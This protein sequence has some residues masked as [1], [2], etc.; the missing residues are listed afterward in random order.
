MSLSY[1]VA[2][3][4]RNLKNC[5]FFCFF[6]KDET[7]AES[8]AFSSSNQSSVIRNAGLNW[9]LCFKISPIFCHSWKRFLFFLSWFISVFFCQR[10]MRMRSCSDWGWWKE[11]V[12]CTSLSL[13]CVI[14]NGCRVVEAFSFHPPFYFQ[15]TSLFS[16]LSHLAPLHV[17]QWRFLLKCLSGWQMRSLNFFFLFGS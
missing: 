17:S 9:C 12:P 8:A 5:F 2:Q 13:L 16:S 3:E 10:Q 14:T 6:F 15:S 4:R 1:C 7:N 11:V